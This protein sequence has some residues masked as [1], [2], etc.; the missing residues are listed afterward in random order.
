MVK[1]EEIDVDYDVEMNE[2]GGAGPDSNQAIKSEKHD[3][4]MEEEK[5][6]SPQPPLG[7]RQRCNTSLEN[8][9]LADSALDSSEQSK[10]KG[11]V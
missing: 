9:G 5:Q 7:D 4:S 1:R 3:P 6:Q 2:Q 8:D 11:S 10:K